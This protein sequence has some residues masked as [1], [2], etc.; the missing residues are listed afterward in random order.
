MSTKAI[1]RKEVLVDELTER[2]KEAKSFVILDYLGLT[3]DEVTKLRVELINN[4]CQ[5][6]VIKN[7]IIRR[8]AEKAGYPEL[9]EHLIGPNAIA[10]SHEDSVSAARVIYDF[11]KDHQT[12]ELKV[13]I[14]DGEYMDHDH[15]TT[16]ATIPSRDTLLTM[17]ASGILQPI[18]EFAIGINMHIEKLEENA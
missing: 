15:I 16:I 8:A 9:T 2:F 11:A 3:V 18:K 5:M 6:H 4:G 17:F 10:F 14:V 13:G 1:E 12:L 7:N